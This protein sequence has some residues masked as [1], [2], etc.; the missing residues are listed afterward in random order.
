MAETTPH[1]LLTLKISGASESLI[2]NTEL[3][4]LLVRMI[5]EAEMIYKERH[6]MGN[7]SSALWFDGYI[8]ALLHIQDTLHD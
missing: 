8:T 4:V 6:Q 5:E 1:E 7:Q 2:A 3:R